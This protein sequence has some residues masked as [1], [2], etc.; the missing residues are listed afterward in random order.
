MVIVTGQSCKFWEM[1]LCAEVVYLLNFKEFNYYD[2]KD[3][4]FPH[5]R[6]LDVE[7]V[8]L[9]FSFACVFCSGAVKPNCASALIF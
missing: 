9:L 5:R 2:R 3:N 4:S 7:T 6:E 8:Q 1:R